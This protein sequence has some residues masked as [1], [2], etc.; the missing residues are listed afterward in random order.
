MTDQQLLLVVNHRDT[1]PLGHVLLAGL[2][3]AQATRGLHIGGLSLSDVR[4]QLASL[5]AGHVSGRDAEQ[6]H[7]RSGGNPFYVSE[8]SHALSQGSVGLLDRP[9][10]AG[11]RDSIRTRLA[12]LSPD[13]IRLLQAASV[14]G[15]EFSLA[16]VTDMLETPELACLPLVEEAVAAGFVAASSPSNHRF[17]HDLVRDAVEA[18]LSAAER[19]RLHRSAAD[20]VERVHAGRLEPHLTDLARHWAGAA[21]SGER[22]RAAEWMRRAAY[23]AMRLLA[24]EEAARLYRLA[25]AVGAA[26]LDDERR[27]RLVLGVAAAL[28]A[29]GEL[30]DRLETCRESAALARRLRRPDLLAEAALAMEGGESDVDA[31]V[32]VRASCEEALALLPPEAGALRA[33][34]SANL[35]NVCM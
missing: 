9:V 30:A 35:A 24:Y 16:L 19:V 4:A 15:R 5:M 2:P 14:V 20:A 6:V 27:C 32:S 34:V 18:G 31:E 23:E 11:V 7:A 26:E 21:A 29:A 10:T 17:A 3:R 12:R 1:E 28:Q 22:V 33:S 13:T 8:L 25:L